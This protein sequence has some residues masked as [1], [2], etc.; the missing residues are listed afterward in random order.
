MAGIAVLDASTLIAMFN[1]N[2][3]HHSWALTVM[4]DTLG[5]DLTMPSLTYAETLVIPF[6]N[7]FVEMFENG[8]SGLDIEVT[9]IPASD[10]PSIAK[11]RAECKLRLPDVVVL[12]S[13]IKQNGA[14]ATA[15]AKLASVARARGLQVFSPS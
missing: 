14:L 9:S 10:A 15:D 1:A 6:E 12:H 8:I 4:N 3:I 13:A 7:E 2:D 5:F 11:L